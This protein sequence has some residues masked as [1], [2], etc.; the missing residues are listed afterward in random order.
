MKNSWKELGLV[1]LKFFIAW[2]LVRAVIRQPNMALQE[3][4]IL[5]I[6]GSVFTFSWLTLA[7]IKE[8]WSGLAA[9]LNI[10]VAAVFFYFQWGDFGL[11]YAQIALGSLLIMSIV[12]LGY[13]L[14]GAARRE[15]G[16]W[17]PVLVNIIVLIGCL[18]GLEA[19]LPLF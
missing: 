19:I 8:A 4:D 14:I 16:I 2:T 12:I 11:L 18:F 7:F 5:V 13:E 3:K 9:A 1:L 6:V 17:L 10:S 15:K